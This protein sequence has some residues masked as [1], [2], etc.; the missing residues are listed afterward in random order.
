MSFKY[1]GA[2]VVAFFS[3]S[4]LLQG[5][6]GGPKECEGVSGNDLETCKKCVESANKNSD[7]SAKALA[8][9][10]CAQVAKTAKDAAAAAT[11]K[12]PNNGK[13]TEE[14]KKPSLQQ[15]TTTPKAQVDNGL[16][17]PKV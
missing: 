13:T 6:S 2:T 8:L 16:P 17:Q 12:A 14:T 15:A 5:C 10:A 4:I 3:V 1:K 11:T 7:S 9:K